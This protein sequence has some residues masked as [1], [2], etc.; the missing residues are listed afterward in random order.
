MDSDTILK[1]ALLIGPLMVAV[2][3]HEVAHGWVARFFGDPT[4]AQLNRLSF[5]PIRHID[6]LGT[7]ILPMGLALSGLP[8]FGWA[9]P[10]P[11]TQSRLRN[12]RFDMIWVALAGPGMNLLL[13]TVGAIALGLFSSMGLPPVVL[14]VAFMFISVNLFLALFNLIPI[15]PF[16]GSKVLG[17]LLPPALG[18]KIAQLDRYG[19]LIFA[20]L[21]LVVPRLLGF[22]VVD[23]VIGPPFE[24]LQA[25]YLR[26]AAMVA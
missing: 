19:F 16:D 12:P 15:P 4:A 17:G 8:V 2:V 23:K 1:G 22:D 10:V 7:I 18:E 6:P 25:F 21:I 20:A 11:V 3:F 24:A 14:A 26:I 5:N 13:A 9:K